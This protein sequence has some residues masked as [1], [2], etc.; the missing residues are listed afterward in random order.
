MMAMGLC[1]HNNHI[2]ESCICIKSFFLLCSSPPSFFPY[3]HR[4]H[5]YYFSGSSAPPNQTPPFL[6]PPP[7]PP[8]PSPSQSSPPLLQHF[9]FM[10]H[11]P[12]SAP[13]PYM[14][15]HHHQYSHSSPRSHSSS[16]STVA[17]VVPSPP[18]SCPSSSAASNHLRYE[19]ILEAPTAAAQKIE[20]APLTYL[21]KG[22]YYTI[23]LVDSEK[24]DGEIASTITIMFHD[25]SHRKVA[26][27]FWKFW[28]SQQKDQES[29]RAIDI[30]TGRC[31]GAFNIQCQF[32]DRISFR[33]NGKAGASICLRFHFL[34]TDF[35]RIKGVKGIPLRLHIA[36]K[37]VDASSPANVAE[38]NTA[39]TELDETQAERSYCQIKLFR[40]KG[41]ERKNKDDARH[42]EKQLEKLRGKNGEPHPLWLAYLQTQPYTV[43]GAVPAS[44]PVPSS[45]A[46][47]LANSGFQQHHHQRMSTYP[48]GNGIATA[49]SGAITSSRGIMS[50][51]LVHAPFQ[52]YG[53]EGGSTVLG[54]KRD[55]HDGIGIFASMS[56]QSS[57]SIP[58]YFV[59]Q[60]I[61]DMDPS[62]IPQQRRRF[63]KLSLFVKFPNEELHRAIYLDQLSSEDLREKLCC[64]LG[65]TD[66]KVQ[67]RIKEVVRCVANKENV[68]V[69]VDDAM[70]GE[71]IE[72]QVM[73]VEIRTNDDGT[74]TLVL[75][76]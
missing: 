75:R 16:S 72:E 67:Y 28:M 21:N 3:H 41:A 48:G 47:M 30:D 69:H 53:G 58:P 35:S 7:Y 15:L 6:L 50:P 26:A 4:Q 9:H 18:S 29:A 51:P 11:Q 63:A 59:Q 73:E 68:I 74:A 33:W 20:D 65:Q 62:Y 61:V 1:N 56:S 52:P 71:M 42:I 19:V 2:S 36:T 10:D 17:S 32:F 46:S 55:H 13:Q 38:T 40:D 70:V 22:Q 12:S 39:T 43:F 44:S 8:L 14:H 23:N 34:S 49:A 54:M 37:V 27:D 31:N 24:Y 66:D 25:E 45:S 76:Y 57:S 60:P 5:H 64:K